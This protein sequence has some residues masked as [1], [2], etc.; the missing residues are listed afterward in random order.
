MRRLILCLV[1]CLSGLLPLA[2]VVADPDPYVVSGIAVDASSSSASQAQNIAI[3]SGRSRAWTTLL[4]RLTKAQDFSKIPVL[5]D[6]AI[7]RMIRTYRFAN[8]RRSTTRYMADITY[9]FN[10]D[11]VRHLLRT[12]NIAYADMQARPILIIPMAPAY[13]P[14]SAWTSIWASPKYATGAAPLVLPAGD[15]LDTAALSV[16]NFNTAAWQDV[17]PAASRARA[18]EAYL[19]WVSQGKGALT[20][21]LK[22][23]AATNSPPIPDVNVPIA[24]GLNGPKVYQGAADAAAAAIV[25]DWKLRSAID[26]NRR[27]KL[28]AEVHINSLADWTQLLQKLATIPTIT[29]VGVVAM[30]TG[31]ARVAITYAG[32]P[33]QLHDLVAQANLDLS[34]D[35]GV[36]WLGPQAPTSVQTGQQ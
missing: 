33:E 25:E 29:D 14:R 13:A 21:K 22:R 5:D 2:P 24:P 20:I 31:E 16:L 18:A 35:D 8:E 36:W 6:T 34:N 26:F 12:A 28:I 4:Q 17:E 30:N 1:F 9:V 32:N 23:L 10:A 19:V 11:A 27:S 15:A 3:V 7:T